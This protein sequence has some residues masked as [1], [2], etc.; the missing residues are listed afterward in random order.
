[1]MHTDKKTKTYALI[2]TCGAA[3]V[4][5]FF[6]NALNLAVPQI[7]ETFGA[8][9]SAAGWVITSFFLVAAGVMLPF[10]RLADIIGRKKLFIP[11]LLISSVFSFLGAYAPSLGWLI[12]FR[13]LQGIGSALIFGTAVAILTSVF[14][15]EERGKVLGINSAILYLGLSLGPAAGGFLIYNWGWTSIF[16]FSGVVTLIIFVLALFRLKGEWVGSPGEPFDLRGSIL[17]TV[18]LGAFLYGLSS[19]HSHLGARFIALGGLL[20][21]LLFARHELRTDYP[22]LPLN[23][24]KK[25]RMFAYSNAVAFLS[26]VAN[27]APLFLMSLYLQSVLHFDAR[28]AGFMLLI[29]PI[30]MVV[31]SP[32]AGRLSD[33][34]NPGS[35]SLIGM[36]IC[37]LSLCLFIIV[38]P[39]TQIFFTAAN[40]ALLGGGF[41]LFATPNSNAIIGSI[42]KKYYGMASSSL[43]SMRLCGQSISMALVT[44][45][46]GH[47][48]G[49]VELSLAPPAQLAA[50]IRMSFAV[51]A[52][53]CIFGVFVAI[54]RNRL[55]KTR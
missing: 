35:V 39:Y 15:P 26:Y 52:G 13:S 1:M 42:D 6:A 47:F 40:L 27:F 54:K 43:G 11:G 23:L 3:F 18:G 53:V 38:G 33:R 51:L 30:I 36:I 44:L 29:Q 8:D 32:L 49:S 22:I 10:G 25:N 17:Y 31:V 41:G 21:L 20:L 12:A 55:N 28:S 19:L 45:V 16:L 50:G 34:I 37:A 2:V 4:P 24:L 5:P 14:P 46:L 9:A 48:V 7:A